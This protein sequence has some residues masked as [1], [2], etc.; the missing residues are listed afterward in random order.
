MNRRILKHIESTVMTL[1]RFF[2]EPIMLILA[3]ALSFSHIYEITSKSELISFAS[4]LAMLSFAAFAVNWSRVPSELCDISIRKKVFSVGLKAMLSSLLFAISVGLAFIAKYTQ[5]QLYYGV[6]LL[7]GLFVLL[8][9]LTSAISI[10][11]MVRCLYTFQDQS[12][13][14]IDLFYRND[15]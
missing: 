15:H 1:I 12:D 3:G 11:E 7:H 10:F 8:G 13:K 5:H 6:F 2:L 9:V 4:S 14:D